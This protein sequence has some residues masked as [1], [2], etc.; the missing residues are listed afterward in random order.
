MSERS[1]QNTM[2]IYRRFGHSA[3]FADVEKSKL[4]R[5]LAL[6]ENTEESFVQTHDVK[7]MSVR[8]IDEAVRKAREE[9]GLAFAKERQELQDKL[10][11]AEKDKKSLQHSIDLQKK[12]P[13]PIPEKVEQEL[14]QL[15]VAAQTAIA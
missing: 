12:E 14:Q 7:S 6:P 3:S 15:R 5:M 4:F 13:A 9:A 1:A 2:A 10:K 11:Q 8:E